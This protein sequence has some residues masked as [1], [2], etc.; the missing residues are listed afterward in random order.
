MVLRLKHWKIR[1]MAMVIIIVISPIF[2]IAAGTQGVKTNEIV[3]GTH[4]AL[5]GPI[6]SWGIE[7]TNAIRMRFEEFNQKGGIFGRKIKYIVED[8]QYRVPIAVHKAN[9]LIHQD[10]VFAMIGSI[11]TPMNQA[12]FRKQFKYNIPSLFPY[13]LARSMVEPHHKLKFMVTSSYYDQMRAGIK[14]FVKKKNK[15]NI[16]LLYVNNDYGKE[17]V[18]AVNDQLH[19]MNMKLTTKIGHK[20]TETN[21]VASIIK[22]KNDKCDLVALGTVVRDT[23]ISVATARRLGW[24][25]DMVSA[26]A[27]CAKIVAEKGGADVEGLYSVTGLE[28]LY[29]EDV[30]GKAKLFFDK[31]K[32]R[33]NKEPSESAQTG[34]MLADITIKALEKAGPN[35]TVDSFIE[36]LESIHSYKSLFGGPIRSF[37]PDKHKGVDQSLLMVIKKGRW[38]LPGGK[39]QLLDY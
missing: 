8:S 21:F 31:Y 14:Y 16:C 4:T 29:E 13:T 1:A 6:A 30:T 28:F 5:S 26:T 35:L 22:L 32:K 37:G 3:F 12:I 27:S 15:K 10:K 18:D 33:Y 20:A 34:Y 25:V 24:N 38:V 23:I 9:K 17:F 7:S 2:S 39:R 19:A 36:G 11:G